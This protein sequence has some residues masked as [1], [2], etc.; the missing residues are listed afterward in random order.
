MI[1]VDMLL[2][3]THYPDTKPISLYFYLSLE[4]HI[5]N[6]EAA[7]TNFI[8]FGLIW[9]GIEHMIFHTQGEHDNHNT[10]SMV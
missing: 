7:K 4:L 1:Q 9:L 3:S 6:Q 8:V 10:T 2:H 5:D